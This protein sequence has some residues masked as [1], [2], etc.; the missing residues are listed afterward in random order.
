M[1]S[2]FDGNSGEGNCGY[3]KA[4]NAKTYYVLKTNFKLLGFLTLRT[5]LVNEI[6]THCSW[7]IV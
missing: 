3:I 5:S 2:D 6:L 4:K 1:Y 7:S